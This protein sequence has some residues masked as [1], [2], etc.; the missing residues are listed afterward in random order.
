MHG[1]PC[2]EPAQ[3]IL[4]ADETI[5]TREIPADFLY[6]AV[7]PLRLAVGS[8]AGAFAATRAGPGSGAKAWLRAAVIP[9][10]TQTKMGP[11]MKKWILLSMLF[12]G[13]APAHAGQELSMENYLKLKNE[14]HVNTYIMG[15][16][17]GITSANTLAKVHSDADFLCI[18]GE[19]NHSLQDVKNIIDNEGAQPWVKQETPVSVVLTIALLKMYACDQP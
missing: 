2:H 11:R 7:L 13:I 12:A 8:A 17:S 3:Q 5:T 6:T 18:P 4:P 15:L 16:E 1:C 14:Q 9:M 19:T 10:T